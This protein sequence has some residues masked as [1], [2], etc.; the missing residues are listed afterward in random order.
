M[1]NI[2]YSK[3]IKNDDISNRKIN[4]ELINFWRKESFL[5]HNIHW[6]K[7]LNIEKINELELTNK[8]NRSDKESVVFLNKLNEKYFSKDLKKFNIELSRN[9]LTLPFL[10]EFDRRTSALE[11]ENFDT[12]N[13]RE[14]LHEILMANII[15]TFIK[16]VHKYK[17]LS[18]TPKE[19]YEEYIQ[20]NLFNNKH[21]FDFYNK[22]TTLYRINSDM[23]N[24]Y[25]NYYIYIHTC[26]KE[27]YSELKYKFKLTEKLTKIDIKCGDMHEQGKSVALISFGTKELIFK[28][29]NL[30]ITKIFYDFLTW[31][32]VYTD[33]KF[34][35]LNYLYF[36]D[37]FIE[38]KI[39]NETC[40]VEREVK[41]YYTRFGGLLAII[42]MLNGNDIH[43]EN[44][45]AFKD[46]PVI[47]DLEALFNNQIEGLFEYDATNIIKYKLA[48]SILGTGMLPKNSFSDKY[49]RGYD[50]SALGSKNQKC[51][52]VLL[53]IH[54]DLTSNIY[55]KEVESKQLE[56]KNLPK[57]N[58][59]SVD[60]YQYS[61]YITNGF[62]NTL[63]ILLNLK[64]KLLQN[65]R[66]LDKFKDVKV[67]TIIR[68]TDFY[69]N[70]LLDSLSPEKAIDPLLRE[71]VLDRLYL[72]HLPTH[73]I[74]EEKYSLLNNNIPV[75]YSNTNTKHIYTNN[76][77]YV[78]F[79]KLTPLELVKHKF[80]KLKESTI[81]NQC[82]ILNKLLL[83]NNEKQITKT[84]KIFL[85]DIEDRDYYPY[86]KWLSKEIKKLLKN[87]YY[88]ETKNQDINWEGI[89]LSLNGTY[90]YNA[91]S[92]NYSDGISGI[93]MLLIQEKSINLDNILKNSILNNVKIHNNHFSSYYGIM[94]ALKP[95][96]LINNKFE[97]QECFDKIISILETYYLN[98]KNIKFIDYFGGL[99]GLLSLL[100][101]V[102][103]ETNN[104]IIKK[105]IKKALKSTEY[106]LMNSEKLLRSDLGFSHG[107]S[108]LIYG[109]LRS[110]EITNNP[111]VLKLVDKIIKHDDERISFENSDYSLSHGLLG[112]LLSRAL[113][114]KYKL[115]YSIKKLTYFIKEN[116]NFNNHSLCNGASGFIE[117]VNIMESLGF[118]NLKS[119]K[120]KLISY[121]IKNN[122]FI[123]GL[124]NHVDV[125][126]I[127]MGKAGYLYTLKRNL[128]K[129][130]IN[131]I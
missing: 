36:K 75:F 25:I 39:E 43:Y 93:I 114:K 80:L 58:G 31:F 97:N 56:N 28:P 38:E 30:K 42:Y 126:N 17:P 117:V 22:Y 23:T 78:N 116:Y 65:E 131:I 57:L 118:N 11:L 52:N 91:L 51:P 86:D 3:E 54:N 35:Q 69:S 103:I 8:I 79:Y 96:I 88:G 61:K 18:K 89:Q 64:T 55:L 71:M 108:G 124:H 102:Y 90:N 99:A 44:I 111:L 81:K 14:Q 104:E 94:S 1:N 95:L 46:Y 45:I 6:Y 87:A 10:N 62:K 48:N 119:E 50:V 66:I 2:L 127:L 82:E 37:F 115:N 107:N 106:S 16:E 128:D 49:G 59:E 13:S 85:K 7:K 121:L 130:I 32:N 9:Y 73:L 76:N 53:Q 70:I 100:R 125:I 27:V 109:L 60:P 123:S 12:E 120:D 20:N 19:Q 41:D 24:Q 4:N 15:R 5:E 63:E 40:S 34:Y 47:V 74:K 29:K 21:L 83:I 77:K 26:I 129:D 68:N 84:N 105:T 122:S 72:S 33:T 67:R 98:I 113:Y 110:Y 92:I 112:I 101:D